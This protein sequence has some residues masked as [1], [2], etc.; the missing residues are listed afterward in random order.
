MRSMKYLLLCALLALTQS[1]PAATV[2]LA[3]SPKLRFVDN[4][5][6]AAVGYKLFTY[7]AGTTTKQ[8]T[9]TDA[10]GATPNANPVILDARGECTCWLDITLA[11]KFVLAP[12]TDTDPPSAPIWTVDNFTTAVVS[13]NL[14]SVGNLTTSGNT[15]LGGV[16]GKTLNVANNA[17]AVDASGNVTMQTG[18]VGIGT[19]SPTVA[20]QVVGSIAAGVTSNSGSS[21]LS[22]INS[23]NGALAA[24]ALSLS[25]DSHL[26]AL[27]VTS[28]GFVGTVVT[29]GPSGEQMLLYPVAAV[30]L[31]LGTNAIARMTFSG[32]S[33]D[34]TAQGVAISRSK[35]AT[36]SR[37]ST[38]TPTA[39]PDLTMPLGV[40]KWGCDLWM[41]VYATSSGAGG[42]QFQFAFTGTATSSAF[43]GTGYINGAVMT[44]SQTS[45][46]VG[47]PAGFSFA[48]IDA[49]TGINVS[50]WVRMSGSIVVSVAG[51]F[52]INW[53]QNSSNAN[54]TNI[55]VGSWLS[56]M[57]VG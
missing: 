9:Y 15:I 23:S 6:N 8:N 28:T 40:G 47:G 29:N 38:T 41:P 7:A 34:I 13:G 27:Q 33:N 14:T 48:T 35:P 3:P 1:A 12:S 11:Y 31:V 2:S 5:G 45:Q 16:A 30:P 54:N 24:T 25:N 19:A 32:T 17:L 46:A 53:A 10:T 21:P 22:V 18:K 39:D 52:S 51:T 26:S 36:T 37:N 44:A 49:Q 20:L 57:K 55:G 4:N 43:S 56:C 42:L 50:D